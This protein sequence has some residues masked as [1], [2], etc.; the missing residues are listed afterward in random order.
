[1]SYTDSNRHQK[2]IHDKSIRKLLEFAWFPTLM[3]NGRRIWLKPYVKT[4]KIIDP[5]L[6][7]EL[8]PSVFVPTKKYTITLSKEESIND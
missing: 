2:H 4:I 6:T 3:D 8:P 7:S 5:T 1:M